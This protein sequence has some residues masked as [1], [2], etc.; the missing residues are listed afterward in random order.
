MTTLTPSPTQTRADRTALH[1]GVHYLLHTLLLTAKNW[2]YVIF[3]I[4]LPLI[5]YLTFS[6]IYGGQ[7]V[8]PGVSYSA[9]IMVQMAAYGALG[10]AMT[11]GA[12]IA[13]ERRSGWFRQLGITVLP[14]RGFLLA[15]AGVVMITVLPA[16]ALVFTA[17]FAIGG[18]RAPVAVWATSLVSIWFALV[19]LAVLGLVVGVWVRGEVVGGL[20]TVLLLVL[21]LAGGLWFP[22]ELMPPAMQQVAVLLPSYWVA[23]FGR[24]PFLGQ[25][26]SITGVIT[27][28]VWTAALTVLGGLGYRRAAAR[29]KR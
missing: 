5:M 7:S 26:P 20:T 14:P 18:V 13:L 23:E 22:I 17:G 4:V 2:S 21:A 12:V 29:S 1:A 24:L 19:P 10:A 16:I 25:P 27:V 9:L 28:L 6:Q 8:A 15:R 11:G 3:T